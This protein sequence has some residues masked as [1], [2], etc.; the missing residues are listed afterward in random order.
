MNYDKQYL[1][2]E[3]VR[4]FRKHD[5]SPKA[6]EWEAINNYPTVWYVRKEFGSW[7]NFLKTAGLSLNT[8][9][10]ERYIICE[11]C[12]KTFATTRVN[13]KIC[14]SK[15][16]RYI[17]DS[18]YHVDSLKKRYKCSLFH[19]IPNDKLIEHFACIYD[20]KKKNLNTIEVI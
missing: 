20:I 19:Y 9:A 3:A 14:D 10:K 8:Q 6:A 1:L 11:I 16:C 2:A 7:T 5:R 18:I 13:G 15:K 4:F 12:K 17:R